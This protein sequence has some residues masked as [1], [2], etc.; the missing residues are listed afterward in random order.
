MVNPLCLNSRVSR[1]RVEV[2]KK[3]LVG[4]QFYSFK[5]YRKKDKKI[6]LKTKHLEISKK[7]YS[8]SLK[9]YCR[10]IITPN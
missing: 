9:F 7:T 4:T 2:L 10:L 1:G 5:K 3:G 8:M 6:K